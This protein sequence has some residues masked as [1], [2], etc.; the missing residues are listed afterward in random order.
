MASFS[1]DDQAEVF[2][3]HAEIS[4]HVSQ[5][6][7]DG[8][9]RKIGPRLYTTNVDD[10][11]DEIVRRNRWQIVNLLFPDTV[12]SHRTAFEGRPADDGT[13]F[14]TGSY[15][16]LQELPGLNISLRKGPGPLEGDRPFLGDLWM[17]SEARAYLE[18]LKPSRAGRTV[19]RGLTR[20]QVEDRLERK[21]Q[22]AGADR[23][24]ELRDHA[25]RIAPGL[26]AE[27][28]FATLDD[29]IGTLLGT[30]KERMEAPSARA[31]VSGAPYDGVRIEM[32]QS[33]FET[34]RGQE[35]PRLPDAL[36][37]D[38]FRHLAFF[39]AYFSNYIEGTEFEVDE[40]AA[41]VFDGAIPEARPEDAHDVL[42]TYGL[43]SRRDV[44]GQRATDL[45]TGDEF[46]DRLRAHHARMLS[47]RPEMDPGV[48][49]E[50]PNRVGATVFV[51]PE[52]VRGTLLRG[53]ELARG[54]E[55][56]FGRA[57]FMSLLIT[58]VHPFRD[59]NGRIARLMMNAE[60]V[61]V[62]ER[63][64]LVPI[65]Y[66]EDY[67]LALR[68]FSRSRRTGPAIRMFAR[69]QRFTAEI[70]FSDWDR[71]GRDLRRCGAFDDPETARLRLPGELG[72]DTR[73]PR[74]GEGRPPA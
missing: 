18:V 11:V 17:A 69:A 59:G 2:A 7:S 35:L 62:G 48:F 39:D 27:D 24:N 12:V 47:R 10:S 72:L 46:L 64:I 56:A 23:V 34:L 38:D 70:D 26:E 19:A 50:R 5:A 3:S 8:R 57:V 45:A 44:I 40:A 9:A 22:R 54:L 21:L 42:G 52:L 31:R 58:E 53:F 4:R 55:S 51:M 61:A 73:V 41:I 30:R 33:L 6:V 65:G 36:E 63:R 67:L 28:Q 43:V 49:K 37:A 16:R 68:A 29:L 20:E 1:L 25:R 74:T 14:L 66:R 15:N 13:V 32:F 60:L 71:V